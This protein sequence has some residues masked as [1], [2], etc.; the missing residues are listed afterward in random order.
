MP[1]GTS[2][3]TFFEDDLQH[4]LGIDRTPNKADA[5]APTSKESRDDN[6]VTPDRADQAKQKDKIE[7]SPDLGGMPISDK[8]TITVRSLNGYDT[9]L[10]PEEQSSYDTKY[11]PNATRDYDMQGY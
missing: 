4:Q 8:G 10:T 5:L 1:V 9:P 6:V 11:G 7:L 3:G 2:L